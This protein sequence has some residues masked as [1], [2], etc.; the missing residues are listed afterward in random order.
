MLANPFLSSRSVLS[1]QKALELIH[2][3][4]ENARKAKD[5]E[6]ALVLCDDAEASLSLMRKIAKKAQD[7][8]NSADKPLR[9]QIATAY[10]DHSELLER[11]GHHDKAQVSYKKAEKW[12]YVRE[13]QQQSKPSQSSHDFSSIHQALVPRAALS[14]TPSISTPMNQGIPSRSIAYVPQEIFSK[15]VSPPVANYDLPESDERITSTPQLAYCLKLLPSPSLFEESLGKAELDWSQAKVHDLDEQGRLRALATDLVREFIRDELKEPSSVTEIVCLAPVLTKDNFRDLLMTF[16]DGIEQSVLLE[17]HLLDGLAQLMRSAAPEYLDADDLVKILALLNTR[18]KDTHQQSTQHIYELTLTVSRVLD[19]M[20]DCHSSSDPYLVYQAAYA[21]QALQYVPDDETPLQATLRRAGKVAQGI[22]GMVSA[23]KGL[24]LN[25]FIDGLGNIQQG[26]AGAQDVFELAH[27]AYESASSLMESG[28]NLLECLKE[29]LSFTRK[30]VWYPALRGLDTLLLDGQLA[31]FKRLV[32]EAPCRCNLAFQWGVC[33]RLGEISAN[34]VWDIDVRQNSIRF[35]GEL[36][37][38]DVEW[39]QLASI[40][41]YIVHILYQLVDSGGIMAEYAQTQLQELEDDGDAVK[42]GLNQACSKDRPSPYPLRVVAQPTVSPLLD[43]LQNKPDV[44]ADLR[45]LRRRRLNERGSAVYISPQAKPSLQAAD[46]TLFDLA[47]KV[48]EF[49]NSDRQVLL[50][51]GDSGAGKSTFNRALEGDLWRAYKKEDGRIPLFINLPAIEKP[52]QD[53]IAKHL[54]KTGFNE[55][56]IREL[57]DYREF[58][59]ICDG[60]DES[61]QIHNLYMSN[62]LNQPGEWRAKMVISCRTEYLGVDY[63]DRFQPTDRNHAASGLFQEAV[64]APFSMAQVRDYIKLYVSVERPLWQTKDYLQVL[65]QIPH[66]Q[67]LVKNP[68]L[69]TLSLEVLPRLVDPGQD[70][71]GARI[72]R[73]ALYDEFVSQWLERGKKRLAEKTLSRLEAKAFERLADE[74]FTQNGLAYLKELAAAIYEYQKGNPVV[75]YS[76]FKD[77]GTWKETFFSREDEKELLR[78]A[79]PLTRSGSQYRFIHRSLLEY[80]VAR[81][82]FEP[83]VGG[84]NAGLKPSLSRRGSLSSVLSFESREDLE[85]V[86]VVIEQPILDS[87]LGK[88]SFVGEPSIIQFLSDRVQ[89]EPLLRLQLLSTI[90][91]SKTDKA[92][93]RAAANAI[94]ILVKAGEQFIGKDLQGIQIPAADL[95]FGMFD[96]AQLQGA[97]L[98]KTNLQN[99]WLNK[100][101][102]SGA[103][104]KDVHFGELPLLNVSSSVECC[105]CSPDGS[106]YAVAIL[107]GDIYVYDTSDWSNILTIDGHKIVVKALV[108]SAKGDRIACGGGDNNI[109]IW[110]ARTGR[111]RHTFVGHSDSVTCV[112]YSPNGDRIVSGSNDNTLRLWDAETGTCLHV[113]SGHDENIISVAFSPKGNIF[114]SGSSDKTAKIWDAETGACI[115]TLNDHCEW[116]TSIA[117][118]PKGEQIATG[119]QDAIVR[120]WDVE[121]GNMQHSLIGHS[122]RVLCIA[123]SAKGDRVATSSVDTTIRLWDVETGASLSV[124]S[125]HSS[126]VLDVRYLPKAN[127]V[128]SGSSDDTVRLWI[129]KNGSPQSSLNGH[130]SGVTSILYSPNWEQ[131]ASGSNDMTVRLWDVETGYCQYTLRGHSKGVSCIAYSPTGNR[132]ASGSYDMTVRLWDV[133][134]GACIHTFNGHEN[135]IGVLAYSPKANQIASG[136]YDKSVRVWDVETGVSLYVLRDHGQMIN[137]LAYSPSGDVLASSSFDSTVRL[138]DTETG[139]CLH[140]LSGHRMFVTSVAYSPKGNQVASGGFDNTVRLWNVE[141]GDCLNTLSHDFRV[142]GVEYSPTGDQIASRSDDTIV[143]LWDVETGVCRHELMGHDGKVTCMAYSPNGD[144]IATGGQDMTV[145][146]WDVESGQCRLVIEACHNDVMGI[147]WKEESRGTFLV[148]GSSDKSVRQWQINKDTKDDKD[149]HRATMCWSSSQDVLSVSKASIQDVQ[150]LSQVNK[151]LLLQRGA[152]GTPVSSLSLREA[153]KKIISLSSGVSKLKLSSNHEIARSALKDNSHI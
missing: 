148:I 147:A 145:Q 102:L 6:I 54:R 73:V 104:M 143:R 25:G 98:R 9:E 52:E 109:R 141:T 59:L 14:A 1:P 61:Q 151:T 46:D 16:V 13:V 86:D 127:Q 33:Q 140:V 76:H 80:G 70:L 132:I 120:L 135:M 81:A 110:D 44:G 7:P 125:G 83:R 32:C 84:K 17:V 18:L 5:P 60:Y 26:L 47:T 24:D 130:V 96:S 101:D 62:Q 123:Y 21:F 35:L 89:Q 74:G 91:R 118:S 66:L 90:E 29:G 58:I 113:I 107:G 122:G 65:D 99:T 124:L 119:S 2:F 45:Q 37:K 112:A 131:I 57:K 138:W 75:E 30:S 126:M 36:Y 82:V 51:L 68:F 87:P 31:E 4:L 40:K 133:G 85:E 42:R 149:E 95:S 8:Q 22:S 142:D 12:G 92:A 94:T 128:V 93:R 97:D 152:T 56:Q 111:C 64:M 38:N 116:V 72:T 55:P 43:R 20:A 139:S 105:A 15:D 27:S 11:L 88:K 10:F 41:Q 150:G 49:L 146:L 108:Y 103:L 63:K 69:L 39:G 153:S 100:A 115:S 48:R 136:S 78:E 114:A 23:V 129:V 34:P 144:Q 50:L 28:Q 19:S 106:T 71:S 3:Y 117:F 121:T 53:L 79:S 134:T 77:Q 137:G 67:D